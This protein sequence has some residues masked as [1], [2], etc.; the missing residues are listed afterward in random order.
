MATHLSTQETF[1][2]PKRAADI[3][4]GRRD[5]VSTVWRL[6]RMELYKLRRRT[7]SKVVLFALVG[8]VA[9]F[10]VILGFYALSTAH[11]PASSF[12]PPPCAAHSTEYCTTQTYTSAQLEQIKN[13]QVQGFARMLG[14]PGSFMIIVGGLA[15]GILVLLG[16]ALL[17]QIAGTEYT[18]GTIRLLFTRGPT[19]IQCMLGKIIACLVTVVVVL[20]LLI[21]VYV[22]VGMLVYPLAGEPYSYTFGFL[23]AANF[24]STFGNTLL[25]ALIVACSWFAYGLLALFFGTLGRSTAAALGAAFAWY[26][27]ELILNPGLNFIASLIPSGP[28]HN[29][30]QT[31]PNYLLDNNFAALVDH[32][33]NVVKSAGPSAIPDAQALIVIAVYL[34]VLIGGS[35]LLAARRDVT[36]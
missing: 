32:R 27:L 4:T 1:L 12:V 2:E 16:L 6:A 13:S 10:T 20:V 11:A 29:L 22:V 24:W 36:N 21:M 28:L 25:I 5:Y 33:M 19:R 35:C 30:A 31:L 15:Q 18:A 17:G 26:I 7:Y 23:H 9:V 14:F 8:L 3:E 34:V